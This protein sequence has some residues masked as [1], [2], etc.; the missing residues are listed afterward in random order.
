MNK[1]ANWSLAAAL[2]L[3]QGCAVGPDYHRPPTPQVPDSFSQATATPAVQPQASAADD[4][5]WTRFDDPQLTALVNTTLASNYDLRTALANYDAANAL[6]RLARFDQAPTVTLSAQ[7]G[8][9][10]LASDEANGASRSHDLYA[11]KAVLGWELDFFGRV[12]RAV[13]SQ[14]AGTAARAS[15]LQAMQVAVVSQVATTYIDLRAAQRMLTLTNANAESQRQTLAVVQGRLQGGRGS[16]YDLSRAQAQLDTTLS[17]MPQLQARIAVD[18]HRLA[19]LAGLAPAALDAQLQQVVDMPRIPAAIEPGTP[20]QIVRRRPDVAAAEQQ[21]HAATARVGVATADLFPRLS[22]GAAL[23]TYAF[24]GTGLYGGASESNLAVLGIDWSFLDVG[25][26]NS[27]IAAADAEAAGRLAGYQQTVL[28]ALEDV[29]NALVRL[30]RSKEQ[31]LR[32][33]SAA[34]GW[35]NAA[36]LSSARYEAGAIELFELLDVQRSLYEA[37]LQQADSQAGSTTRAVDL[38]VALAGGWPQHPVQ[39]E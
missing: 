37:Q 15:D 29:E 4:A 6:L 34:D 14:Q 22:L 25:R 10:R 30:A 32:L 35:Q 16:S 1:P 20:A 28:V 2:A 19:V 31:T 8:H 5:F 9:Q 21:L 27:R 7:A 39:Q 23:G 36:N 13:E 24:T 38:F 11:N 12:R 33:T 18:K 17:R 26:V 3:L